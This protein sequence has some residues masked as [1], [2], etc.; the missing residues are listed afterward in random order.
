VLVFTGFAWFASTLPDS[1][2]PVLFTIGAAV[3]P[4]FYVGIVYLVISFPSGRLHGTLDRGLVVVTIGLT[5]VVQVA[6]LFFADSR[7]FFC[8]TCPANLLEVAREDAVTRG[9]LYFQRIGVLVLA[10][11]PRRWAPGCRACRT[12]CQRSAAP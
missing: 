12:A 4:L 2:N 11:P 3:Y 7:R 5:T 6:S 9:V 8:R 1:H 10:R